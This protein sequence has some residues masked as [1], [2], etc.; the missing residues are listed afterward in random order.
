MEVANRLKYTP[1]EK[2]SEQAQRSS[3]SF[4][5]C[6]LLTVDVSSTLSSTPVAQIAQVAK[7]GDL[8]VVQ[9]PSSKSLNMG[10]YEEPQ[11]VC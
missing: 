11:N 1:V 2:A 5:R 8:S 3:R 10:L 6:S 7:C 9:N 4:H